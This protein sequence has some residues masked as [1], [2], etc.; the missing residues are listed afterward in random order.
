MAKYQVKINGQATARMWIEADSVEQAKEK[1]D[2][3]INDPDEH[4][5]VE[6]EW[7]MGV[8]MESD[9]KVV[10]GPGIE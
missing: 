5:D 3:V 10:N 9:I 7:D 4:Q 2:E 8:F 1:A 6:V